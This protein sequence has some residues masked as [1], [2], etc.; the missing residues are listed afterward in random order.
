MNIKKIAPL[1]AI[2]LG[3][4]LAFTTSGFKE[5]SMDNTTL[6]FYKYVGPNFDQPNI[7]DRTLYIQA[8]N[9]CSGRHD[10]CG[11]YLPTA[12]GAGNN[13]DPTEFAAES[14]D[15]WAS[16]QNQASSD[17]GTIVMKN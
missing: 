9:A 17:P 1:F 10:V 8:A 14:A 11:V 5:K 13:P 2:A 12:N 15:L 4:V 6:T 16:Q 3:L 7:Q